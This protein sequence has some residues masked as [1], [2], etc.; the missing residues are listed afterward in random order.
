MLGA[1]AYTTIPASIFPTMSFARVDIVANAGDLPPDRVRIEVALPL[2]R[3]FTGLPSVTRVRSTSAQGSAE[4]I[5]EFDPHSDVNVDLQRVFQGIASVRGELPP[6]VTVDATIINPNSEPIV[7]YAFTSSTLSQT[8]VHEILQQTLVPQFYGIPGLSRMLVVGGPEREYVVTLDASAL[9]TRGLSAS[10]VTKALAEANS[11]VSPGVVDA[12]A[13][14]NVLVV[15]SRIADVRSLRSVAI[16]LANHASVPLSAL[17]DVRLGIAPQTLQM[18]YNRTHAVAINFFA[19]PGADAVKMADGVEARMIALAGKLPGG[20]VTKKYWDQTTLIRDSQKSLRDAIAIGAVLAILVILL[21]LRNLRMT[22]IAAFVIPIAIA[23]VIFIIGRL[24]QTLNLMSVGGLAV[25]VGLIIDDAI[26]VIENI[27]RHLSE[28]PDATKATVIGNAMRELI[29][30]MTASTLTTVVV[31]IPLALL[32]GVSGFFFR[33]LAVTLATSLVVSLLLAIFVTPIIASKLVRPIDE[34]KEHAGFI[35]RILAGYEPLLRWAL[36]HRRTIYI[37]SGGVLVVTFLLLS[38]LPSDFL[39]SLDEGQFEIKYRMPVGS[40]LAASDTAALVLERIALADPAVENVGRFTGIDTNGF[41][42][43]P[44][45]VG[46]IRITMRSRS[47]RDSYEVVSDRLRDAMQTAVPAASL[48]FHQILEDLIN[49]VSGAPAPIQ[50]TIH[51]ADQ[52]ALIALATAISVNFGKLDGVTDVFSGVSFDDP[53]VRISPNGSRL[54]ALGIGSSAVADAL[55]AATLGNVATQL[56]GA[57]QLVPVRVRVGDA[58]VPLTRRLLPTAGGAVPIGSLAQA[59]K[60]GASSDITEENGARIMVVTANFSGKSLS[61]V[62]AEIK[63]S[64]AKTP[65]P[66]GYSWTIGGQYEAQ[67]ASFKEFAT[68]IAIAIALVFFVMVVTFRSYRLPLVILTAIP[69]ALIGVALGLF[70]TRTPFNVSSFMGLLL[71]VGLIVKNGI[72]LI[73]V[74]NRRR[75]EGASIEDALVAAGRLR[76]RPIV[77]TT[78]AAIGGLLPL[79]LGLGSGAEME[80]PLAI[81]VIGGLSTATIFTLIAIPVLYAGF[82]EFG[83]QPK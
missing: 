69:L 75:H 83:E 68:V 77:M 42:P 41:S 27:A 74:A 58:S 56:P 82:A 20:L 60:T 35:P 61:S 49:D 65:F 2:E 67:Q 80:K 12:Y 3:A 54:A 81:A 46:T 4:L 23:V 37:A 9:A 40:T 16:P 8:I 76:L 21:F 45:R 57:L 63:D 66:P 38:R 18:S 1:W 51:G 11:V 48:D 14:R 24:N 34:S 32:S 31:F 71:L 79:A 59:T 6:A 19:L 53:T 55:G 33:A 62:V 52:S 7:S 13:Q 50:L 78:F 39:P 72:L 44:P 73:D 28:E 25:A 10:D 17:A 5:A 64:L 29:A 70:L 22:L 26:V 30:P 43:T 15:D 36:E 47:Q